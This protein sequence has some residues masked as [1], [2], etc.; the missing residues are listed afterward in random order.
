[1]GKLEAAAEPKDK[2]APIDLDKPRWDQSTYMG[3]V[4]HFVALT[5][6]INFFAA[7]KDLDDA[8]AVVDEYKFVHSVF[9]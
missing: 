9:K 6:P 7:E 2:D 1:M 3:R 4:K 8:K 5:N